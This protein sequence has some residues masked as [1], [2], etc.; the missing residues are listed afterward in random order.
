MIRDD[1]KRIQG[2]GN[3]EYPLIVSGQDITEMADNLTQGLLW[4]T[5]DELAYH[6]SIDTMMGDVLAMAD[7]CDYD[8]NIGRD[9]WLTESRWS[10]LIRQ[11]VNPVWLFTFLEGVKELSTY[12][13]GIV[14]MD[15]Q[16]VEPTFVESNAR[17]NRRK[18]G[19]CMRFMTYRA[20][21]YPTITLY[22]RTSYIG[23]VGAL[24]LLLAHK[25]VELA[26]DMIGEGLKVSD[27]Q[28][29]WHV[30][31]VQWHGFKSMAYI[32]AAGLEDYVEGEWPKGKIITH[33]V[34]G[35]RYRI[36]DE[37]LYPSWKITRSWYQRIQ[38]LDR[39]GILY[40]DMK[41]GAE[42]R[43]RRRLHAQTGVDQDPFLGDENEYKPLDL[44][45][46]QVT[47]DR[48][49]Y[50]TPESRAIV[51]RKKKEK[52]EALVNEIFADDDIIASTGALDDLEG[53]T[54]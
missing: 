2:A 22:S 12:G 33:P 23:Y 40:Q 48:M 20:F 44:P 7:S 6:S 11:Y 19:S 29:R 30:E 31:A 49:I 53:E 51:K 36:K 25:I 47:L 42:K 26:A 16:R 24:D 34:T 39:E 17:A 38:R 32:F 41:Y 3:Q 54:A 35:E 28:F 46:D 18:R 15:M 8:L 13:R 27:F 1:Y 43:V 14:A 50:K 5:K 37:A 9:V 52:A 21:P 45:I 10:T 4:A